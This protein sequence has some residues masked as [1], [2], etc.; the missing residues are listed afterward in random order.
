MKKTESPFELIRLQDIIVNKKYFPLLE[1]NRLTSFP[2][3]MNY[4]GG[5]IVKKLIPERFIITFTLKS[6]NTTLGFFLKRY[7]P[8][9]AKYILQSLL[10]FVSPYSALRE[11]DTIISFHRANLPTVIPVAAGTRR[12]GF[13]GRESFLLTKGLEGVTRL[14]DL[15]TERFLPPLSPESI[16]E[17]R[18][19]ISKLALLTRRMH[20]LGFNHRD[21]YLCHILA[22]RDAD[23][24]WELFICDLHRVDKREK[25]GMRWRVKDLAA[26]N[27]SAPE[28]FISARDRIRFLKQYLGK[29]RL[30]R[31]ARLWIG[32]VV[33][34]TGKMKRHN[35][36]RKGADQ[37]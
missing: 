2:S 25:T 27:Y 23:H 9:P 22:R 12:K 19:L 32:K 33:K 3:L 14:E 34:K 21:F 1:E 15:I 8:S 24:E 30:D 18:T 20:D 4:A 11:W 6:A 36:R 5:Q 35:A 10:A 37:L 26:L 16:S 13:L 31:E 28:K 29:T 17:K 7:Y